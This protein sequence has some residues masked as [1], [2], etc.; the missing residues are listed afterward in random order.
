MRAS[1]RG[2]GLLPP[3]PQL[4]HLSVTDEKLRLKR[5]EDVTCL[6]SH[7]PRTTFAA[8]QSGVLTTLNWQSDWLS[9]TPPQTPRQKPRQL[10]FPLRKIHTHTHAQCAPE[11]PP[12]PPPSPT[13][14]ACV[15][16]LLPPRPF[17]PRRSVY[18]PPL[19]LPEISLVL[20]DVVVSPR[21]TWG[22]CY[23]ITGPRR[24]HGGGG[25]SEREGR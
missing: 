5:K 7:K 2:L 14:H 18:S 21:D 19:S 3:S 8:S 4:Y 11:T 10:S 9:L 20:P 16:R 22:R 6:Y 1:D 15:R 23:V 12:G 17:T 13:H 24:K 25:R